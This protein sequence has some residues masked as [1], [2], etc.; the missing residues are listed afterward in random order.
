MAFHDA[1]QGLDPAQLSICVKYLFLIGGYDKIDNEDNVRSKDLD[2]W[3]DAIRQA[4]G[5]VSKMQKQLEEK[6][7]LKD[8]QY[9]LATLFHYSDTSLARC[10]GSDHVGF[11]ITTRRAKQ[12][13]LVAFISGLSLPTVVRADANGDGK[14]RVVGPAFFGDLMDGRVWCR[15]VENG[16]EDIFLC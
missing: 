9:R 4:D 8:T 10:S 12:G 2:A 11:G 14:F 5:D 1:V 16:L 13:D 7:N 15:G 3:C 6:T